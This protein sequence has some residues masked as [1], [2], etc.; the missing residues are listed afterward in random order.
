MSQTHC[1]H[2]PAEINTEGTTRYCRA[3]ERDANAALEV[4]NRVCNEHSLACGGS[5]ACPSLRGGLDRLRSTRVGTR[6]RWFLE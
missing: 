1:G 4:V 5:G 2:D 6:R 3:C